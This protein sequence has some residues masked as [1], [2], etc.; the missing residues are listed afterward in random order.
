MAFTTLSED[1]ANIAS[2][3][4]KRG[5][6]MDALQTSSALAE[7]AGVKTEDLYEALATGRDK[8]DPDYWSFQIMKYLYTY[9]PFGVVGRWFV[10][11]ILGY[12]LF[13]SFAKIGELIG[14][15]WDSLKGA[16]WFK[17][18]GKATGLWDRERVAFFSENSSMTASST[19]DSA[20]MQAGL[21]AIL[22]PYAATIV[23][24]AGAPSASDPVLQTRLSQCEAALAACRA[25]LADAQARLS[26]YG[27]G[28]MY[29]N[30]VN[31]TLNPYS[32]AA[33]RPYPANTGGPMFGSLPAAQQPQQQQRPNLGEQLG[34]YA[35]KQVIDWLG[36]SI[37]GGNQDDSGWFSDN[38]A[39]DRIIRDVN[40]STNLGLKMNARSN[41]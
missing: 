31:T 20:M 1:A 3:R 41:Y 14:K 21:L 38:V 36:N 28:S 33:P 23:A 18:A 13:C 17:A 15:G 4:A 5:Q 11:I 6:I 2:A 22:P 37:G 16:E 32:S 19:V 7:G 40:G 35:G 27:D 29:A 39:R 34:V 8:T 9:M 26:Q 25:D 10:P 30:I 24:K 12:G